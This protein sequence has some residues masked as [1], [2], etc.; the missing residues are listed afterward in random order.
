LQNI[1]GS[2]LSVC[3]QALQKAIR[4]NE[5]LSQSDTIDADDFEESSLMFEQELVRLCRLY[6]D[7]ESRNGVP[8]PLAQLLK[9]PY[10]SAEFIASI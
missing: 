6:R 3:I 7:E 5:F 2:S 4:F 9:P 10:D 1:N 8:I